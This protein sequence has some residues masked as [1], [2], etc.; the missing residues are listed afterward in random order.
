[1]V[2][3]GFPGHAGPA[4]E[5]EQ[6]GGRYTTPRR[7]NGRGARPASNI[8]RILCIIQTTGPGQT[9]PFVCLG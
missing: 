2:A 8:A 7:P 3:T 5:A 1:L 9:L 4:P 6:N